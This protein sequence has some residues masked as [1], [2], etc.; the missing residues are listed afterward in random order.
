MDF[1]R[2]RRARGRRKY[3]LCSRAHCRAGEGFV[4]CGE[5]SCSAVFNDRDFAVMGEFDGRRLVGLEYE[6][7]FNVHALQSENRIKFIRRI[8]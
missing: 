2:E 3:F 1:A 6:P 5:G 4:Y 8:L 7:L